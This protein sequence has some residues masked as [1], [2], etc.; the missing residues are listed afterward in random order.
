MRR[1]TSLLA[2]CMLVTAACRPQIGPSQTPTPSSIAGSLVPSQAMAVGLHLPGALGSLA[3]PVLDVGIS[4]SL[5]AAN[6]SVSSEPFSGGDQ[7]FV[8]AG[9]TD[10]VDLF[11]A[12][13]AAAV[14]ANAAGGDLELVASL[15]R[16]SSWRLMTL[17]TSF[18]ITTQ[19]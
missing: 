7:A 8:G 10:A 12:S 17:A 6:I 11:V 9:R 15:Q 13:T 18:S 3:G 16:T 14:A 5:A 2:L 1:I 19:I 4:G